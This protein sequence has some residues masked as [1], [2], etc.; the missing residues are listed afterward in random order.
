MPQPHLEN[1]TTYRALR[2]TR[3]DKIKNFRAQV[4][5]SAVALPEHGATNIGGLSLGVPNVNSV[6]GLCETGSSWELFH[7]TGRPSIHEVDRS[8]KPIENTN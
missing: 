1:G 4:Q 8:E 6:E 3:L 2:P 7:E 5:I